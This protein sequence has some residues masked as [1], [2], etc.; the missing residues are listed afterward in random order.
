MEVAQ[1]RYADVTVLR[2]AGRLDHGSSAA[3][4]NVLM[5]AIGDAGAARVVVDASAVDY[6][7]SAGLRAFMIAFKQCRGGGG[8]LAIA[9]LKPLVAEIF[10]I[11]R[12]DKVLEIHGSAADALAALSPEARA[13]FDAANPR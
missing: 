1:S 13:A 9:A 10:Q 6:V 4:Q 3:F 8:R 2:P 11:S 5:R 12:F 7:S